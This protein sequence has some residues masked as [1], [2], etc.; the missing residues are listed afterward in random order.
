MGLFDVFKSRK[1]KAVTVSKYKLI[2][3]IGN[4]FYSWNGNI[5]KSDIV[6]A[7]IRP[8]AQAIGKLVGKHIRETV[9]NGSTDIIVNPEPYIRFLLEEP[10]PYM[11]GQMLQ[12]KLA[13]QLEL[14]NNAFAYIARDEFGYPMQIYPIT[15]VACEAIQD[16]VGELYLRFVLING[17]TI[18]FKYT[19]IIHL[20]KDFNNNE[21]FGDS[22]TET[23]IPLMEIITT[24]DQGIVKAIKNSNAIKW[25]LKYNTTLRPEDIKRQTKE[26]VDNFLNI[27][28]ETVGAAAVDVKTD[29]QQVVPQDYVPNAAQIDRAVQRI[30]SFFN[31]N[32][33]IIQGNYSEN[34]WISYYESSIEPVVVQ[35]SGEYTRK[36]FSRRERGFGNKIVFESSNL[37][38][39]SMQTKLNLVNFVDRGILNP[40]EV[41]AILN[42]APIPGGEVYLRRLDTRPADE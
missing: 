26:F 5:Y 34:E 13:T 17:K 37:T 1:N 41:R 38:F 2:T 23:L 20:R 30:Y 39:A 18:T 42:L 9:V 12:E 31:T 3:D 21:I 14:N 22:P 19:D 32:S 4:G 10:N 8:K 7:A 40:N 6:R 35:L 15:A 25:L 36:L 11:T 27:E 29:A 24:T 33:K 16:S 28:S